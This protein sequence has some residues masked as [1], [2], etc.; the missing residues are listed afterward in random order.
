MRY[1]CGHHPKTAFK[2]ASQTGSTTLS[3]SLNSPVSIPLGPQSPGD[4]G[5]LL[6]PCRF[7]RCRRSA[8]W[9]RSKPNLGT[10]EVHGSPQF[11][12]RIANHTFWP[13]AFSIFNWWP[14]LR[15]T[16]KRS[17]TF[18]SASSWPTRWK[19]LVRPSWLLVDQ[20]SRIGIWKIYENL[21]CGHLWHVDI[22]WSCWVATHHDPSIPSWEDPDFQ[23]PSAAPWQ[24]AG[25]DGWGFQ[26]LVDHLSEETAAWPSLGPAQ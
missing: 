3:T 1:N 15:N 8:G 21:R 17:A 20:L 2:K 26:T 6:L 12:Y 7:R 24:N 16:M 22:C 10:M 19:S 11:W 5:N 4:V 13:D 23:H 14:Q 25:R 18:S 9:G